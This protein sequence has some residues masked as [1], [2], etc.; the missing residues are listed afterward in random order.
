MRIPLIIQLAA[1][2]R[3]SRYIRATVLFI[4]MITGYSGTVF[5]NQIEVITES[6]GQG[7]MIIGKLSGNGK[8]FVGSQELQ[9]TRNGYFVFGVGRDAPSE[10]T[11]NAKFNT[12]EKSLSIPIKSRHWKIERVNG[13]PP[14]KVNP[15]SKAVLARITKEARL[16]K[17]ARN[18]ESEMEYFKMKFIMPAKG[19]ISGV[20]GSQRVLN[21]EPKRPHYGLDIANKTGSKV[22]APAD[23]VV[24]LIHS[25]MFY[26]G[27]TIVIDHGYGI[28]STY[29]HLNSI[30]VKN[31]QKVAQGESIGTI[32]ATGRASGPHLDWRLNWFNTRLDPQ[33]LIND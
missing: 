9:L 24:S 32:G 22:I 30:S 13:L 18:R 33:L 16:V 12:E 14:S 19:R 26:S 21:G 5:A 4:L 25:N 28:S 11:I 29:I 17:A 23:G 1:S 10:V 20:Y 7:S 6:P 27:G 8:V 2:H 31:G 15:K 3:I